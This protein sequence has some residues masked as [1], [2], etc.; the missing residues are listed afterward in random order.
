VQQMRALR[1]S[2][3][4]VKEI[5]RRIRAYR[6]RH[7]DGAR[8]ALTDTPDYRLSTK[9]SK[10]L[11]LNEIWSLLTPDINNMVYKYLMTELFTRHCSR[12]GVNG[13][14]EMTCMNY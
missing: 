14:L 13:A 8:P 5:P 7:P 9:G 3:R 6:I 2:R 4:Y 10:R 12:Y 1:E 11:E